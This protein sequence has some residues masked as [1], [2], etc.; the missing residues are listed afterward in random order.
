[1]RLPLLVFHICAGITGILSGAAAMTFRKGSPRHKAAGSI[2]VIAMM[3][4]SSSAVYLALMKHQLNNFFGGILA[5]Y[6]VVTAW[7]TARRKDGETSVFD[8]GALAVALAVGARILAYGLEAARSQKGSIGGVP[9]GMFFFL[10][11]VAVLAAAGDIRMLARG[12]VFGPKRVVRHLWRMCFSFFIATGSFFI[13]QQQVFP[14]A[15]RKANVLFVP[16]LLPLVL[17]IFWLFRGRFTN[18]YKKKSL[19]SSGD[20]H[21]LPP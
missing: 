17:L 4:M 16:A 12:G 5:F 20:V 11:S 21:S 14:A 6:L 1:M 10:G 9:A 8:W 2:F 7:L 13:G 18:A 19:P 3:A 15:I